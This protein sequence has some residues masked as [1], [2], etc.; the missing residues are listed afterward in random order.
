MA[1]RIFYFLAILFIFPVNYFFLIKSS[2]SQVNENKS[3]SLSIEY[4]KKVPDYDYIIGPGDTINII[5]S[6][7]YPE[8]NSTVTIDGEG[9]INLPKLENIFVENLSTNE[10]KDLLN[11]AYMKY[12]KY[13]SV[14]VYIKNYRSIKVLVQG[15]VEKPGLINLEGS[16]S[17][18]RSD[19]V[20]KNLTLNSD[21]N[22]E[23]DPGLFSEKKYNY[24]FPTVLD[25]IRESGDNT[26]F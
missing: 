13:P 4:F 19:Y 9:T 10:L 11:K 8:L 15:E 17:V 12:V 1:K 24:Y 18:R 22:I 21:Q 25:A 26:F 2:N 16:L 3:N 20:S 14:E 5:V 7:D 6:R 23:V